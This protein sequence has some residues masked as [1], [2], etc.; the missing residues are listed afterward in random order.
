MHRACQEQLLIINNCE[1]DGTA[2]GSFCQGCFTLRAKE[3][4]STRKSGTNESKNNDV[5]K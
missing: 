4:T 2:P 3:I 1:E 5:D